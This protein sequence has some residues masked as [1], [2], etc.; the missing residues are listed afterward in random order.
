MEDKFGY[1]RSK[2]TYTDNKLI[3]V[4][5]QSVMMDWEIPVMKKVSEI[6]TQ[7]KGDILNIGFGMGIIDTMIQETSPKSHTIIETHPDVHKK[8]KD[9]GWLDKKNVTIINDK[10]QNQ[11]N[12]LPTFDGIYLDTWYDDRVN[13]VKPLLDNCL[14]KGGVFSMWYNYNEFNSVLDTL[15][16]KYEVGYEYVK[17][18][19]LIPSAKEQYENGGYYINPNLKNIT[20]P[21]II[22]K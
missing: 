3:N 14:K 18:D 20:I 2:Y 10:W 11:I 15:D 16:D 9:D 21:F 13:Y 12:K 7:R 1:D 5:G 22:K 19:N 6:I 17:N 8:I 4:D